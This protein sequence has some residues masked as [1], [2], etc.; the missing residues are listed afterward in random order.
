MA[1]LFN[2][3][4]EA[5]A[6]EGIA[7]K[8]AMILPTLILQKPFRTLKTKDHIK[9]MERRIKLWQEGK[10]LA[11]L[12]EGRSIQ[13]R[14]SPRQPK[15]DPNARGRKI[16]ELLMKG[17]IK[18]ASRLITDFKATPLQLDKM[19]ENKTVRDILSEKHPASRPV[20]QTALL[21]K[22]YESPKTHH[23]MIFD[24]LDG[25]CILRAALKTDGGAGPSGMDACLW[26]RMCLSFQSA[27]SN[28]CSALALVARR[29]ASSPVDPKPLMPLTSS[30]LIAL[31]E[32]PG[33]RPIGIGEVSR[34]IIGKSRM[35]SALIS[36]VLDR[37][38][39]VRQPSMPLMKFLRWKPLKEF[40]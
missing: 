27:S 19:I 13:H 5:S 17:K 31:D 11:L 2:A 12:D 29:I 24:E 28:L 1:H 10:L 18:A 35:Q 26:K 16:A 34:R 36:F 40:L 15:C 39:A 30:R 33:V 32:C 22:N 7:L 8:A 38:T 14:L 9:C 3:Y 25:M 21:D 37:N 23:P 4:G 6:M 20:R